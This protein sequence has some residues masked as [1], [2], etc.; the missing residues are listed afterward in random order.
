MKNI[1]II[2]NP[3]LLFLPFLILYTVFI[4]IFAK[5]GIHGD[6]GR[7]LDYANNLTHGFYSPA[8]PYIDL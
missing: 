6:E 4:I 3:F 5:N 7:Y 1:K 2:K 8:Y